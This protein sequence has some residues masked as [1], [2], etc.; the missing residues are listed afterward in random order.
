MSKSDEFDG[1][2]L[3]SWP[4]A[5]SPPPASSSNPKKTTKKKTPETPAVTLTDDERRSRPSYRGD[6]VDLADAFNDEDADEVFNDFAAEDAAAAADTVIELAH[7]PLKLSRGRSRRSS[8][9]D[10]H[11]KAVAQ[12][13]QL[14]NQFGG[15]IYAAPNLD[16]PDD[17]VADGVPAMKPAAVRNPTV[18]SQSITL[19]GVE[20]Q[21]STSPL[22]TNK[23]CFAATKRWHQNQRDSLSPEALDLFWKSAT[24]DVLPGHNKLEAMSIKQDDDKLLFFVKNLGSQLKALEAHCY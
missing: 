1:S 3:S 19:R 16:D 12:S 8:I 2:D 24:G 7:T 9:S 13:N 20:L 22:A 18:S 11:L 17:D 15:K 6:G 23:S 5:L 14:N 21:L 4:A 10:L